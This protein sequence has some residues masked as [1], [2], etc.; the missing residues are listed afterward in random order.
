MARFLI[1]PMIFYNYLEL[2]RIFVIYHVSNSGTEKSISSAEQSF[3]T[4]NL[5]TKVARLGDIKIAREGNA[6]NGSSRDS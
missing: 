4:S 5:A 3:L 6:A 2:K 1:M